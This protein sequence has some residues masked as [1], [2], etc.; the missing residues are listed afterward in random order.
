MQVG[1][2]ITR[3]DITNSVRCSEHYCAV[4]L[5][6][7]RVFIS[8]HIA[9]NKDYI[10]IEGAGVI[11]ETPFEIKQFITSYD[12]NLPVTPFAFKMNVPFWLIKDPYGLQQVPS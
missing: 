4:A 9:V 5:A 1:V 2:T 6:L 11:C 7:R 12:N 10:W 3:K 8:K